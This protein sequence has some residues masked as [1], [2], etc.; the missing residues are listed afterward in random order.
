M[1]TMESKIDTVTCPVCGKVHERRKIMIWFAVYLL[2]L[3]ANIICLLSAGIE[4]NNPR[5][6]VSIICVMLA[7]FA[8]RYGG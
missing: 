7:Y 5:Y 8:G 4:T 2:V 1:S 6:W 3:V